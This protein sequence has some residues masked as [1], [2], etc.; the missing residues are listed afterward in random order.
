MATRTWPTRSET[1]ATICAAHGPTSAS[2]PLFQVEEAPAVPGASSRVG[3]PRRDYA[4]ARMTATTATPYGRG[5]TDASS[6]LD[7]RVDVIVALRRPSTGC[8][9]P[10]LATVRILDRWLS[11]AS[12]QP[13]HRERPGP[14]RLRSHPG[15]ARCG[16]R[17]PPPTGLL[18]RGGDRAPRR[19]RAVTAAAM[20]HAQ[21]RFDQGL[22]PVAVVTEFRILRQEIGRAMARTLDAGP[23]RATSWPA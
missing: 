6:D 1:P 10:R 22:G 23:R 13:F 18:R 3:Y 21:A 5:A 12:R 14:R 4:H 2:R 11:V 15:A 19:P 8:G 17:R 7:S 9:R 20:A 16:R